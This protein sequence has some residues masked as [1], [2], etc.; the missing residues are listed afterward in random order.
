MVFKK[1]QILVEMMIALGMAVVGLLSLV[2]VANKSIANSGFAK[3]Q[4]QA[5]GYTT[6]IIEYVRNQKELLGWEAFQAN[7]SGNRCFNGTN[8]AASP[9]CSIS[10]T[11]FT[12]SVRI[13]FD[14]ITPP[15]TG[16]DRMRVEAE[17][18]WEEGGRTQHSRQNTQ[19][20]RY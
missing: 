9:S 4:M 16:I 5:N 1:G 15:A 18:N 12:S 10:G 19:F 11:E 3:R 7:Y 20:T 8:I 14:R 2:I 6:Q 17:V 13:N